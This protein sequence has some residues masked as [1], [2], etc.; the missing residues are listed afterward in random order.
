MQN[1][2]KYILKSTFMMICF[3]TFF[4]N[5]HALK[6]HSKPQSNVSYK[7]DKSSVSVGDVFTVS[8][9][10]NNVD[11]LYGVSLDINY[12]SNKVKIYD[13]LKTTPFDVTDTYSKVINNDP[14]KGT[15]SL[16]STLTGSKMGISNKSLELFKLQ[17]KAISDGTFD[18]NSLFKNNNITIKLSNNI[19]QPINFN[20]DS[21]KINIYK[22]TVISKIESSNNTSEAFVGQTLT[23]NTKYSSGTSPM[24][25]YWVKKDSGDW[26]LLSN[27]SKD[28][29]LIWKP[30]EPGNY[31]ISCY[32]KSEFSP[33]D[34]DDYKIINV[35]VVDKPQLKVSLKNPLISPGEEIDLIATSNF[36]NMQYKF[37]INDGSGWKVIQD[38]SNNNKLNYKIKNPGKYKISVYTR[39][40]NSTNEVD[41]YQIVPID[42]LPNVNLEL[43]NSAFTNSAVKINAIPETKGDYLY[44]FWVN[45]ND[46]WKVIQDFSDNPNCIW[47][48]TTSGKK[49]LSVYIKNKNSDVIKHSVLPVDVKNTSVSI[50]SFNGNN[51]LKLGDTLSLKVNSNNPNAEFKYWLLD[52]SGSWKVLKDYSPAKELNFKITDYGNFKISVYVKDKTSSNNP[53]VYKV[54]DFSITK[55][56]IK[57]NTLDIKSTNNFYSNYPIKIK[58]ST[59]VDSVL[60]KFWVKELNGNWQVIQDYSPSPETT[61]TPKKPGDYIFSVYVKDKNSSKEVDAHK[62]S[63]NVSIKAPKITNISLSSLDNKNN[64]LKVETD[65][66]DNILYKYFYKENN[67]LVLLKDYSD[68]NTLELP[69]TFKGTVSIYVKDKLS[70]NELYNSKL[71]EIK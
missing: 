42:V 13:V 10:S 7:V 63:P 52:S 69:K 12:D 53:D 6:V 25:K 2:K 5:V 36:N 71:F 26:N 9:I 40:I 38:Y 17:F 39:H 41:N 19:G 27:Y 21:L 43:P 31:S 70:N 32:A 54:I 15:L 59:N 3:L 48:P 65:K 49:T 18:L 16:F 55:P 33:N 22:P 1:I 46:N 24:F 44:K 60:Y 62:I 66:K 23:F 56:S 50:G 30:M 51:G 35:K 57:V 45:E 58:A 8:I 34:P 14:S 4:L 29:K 67:K 11:N 47:Y 28:S 20:K 61:W 37:W 64:L 68:N